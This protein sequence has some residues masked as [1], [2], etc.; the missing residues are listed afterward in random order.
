MVCVSALVSEASINIDTMA[1]SLSNTIR[2]LERQKDDNAINFIDMRGKLTSCGENTEEDRNREV[3]QLTEAIQSYSSRLKVFSLHNNLLSNG[4][5][6]ALIKVLGDLVVLEKLVIFHHDLKD[7]M[8]GLLVDRLSGSYINSDIRNWDDPKIYENNAAERPSVSGLKE[9]YL[10][11]CNIGCKGALKI[12]EALVDSSLPSENVNRLKCLQV[13]SLG[14][15]KIDKE[16]GLSL[17]KVFASYPSLHRMVLHGNEGLTSDTDEEFLRY[18]FD[19]NGWQQSIGSQ[20]IHAAP[21][22]MIASLVIPYV[23]SRWTRDRVLIRPYELSRERLLEAICKKDS[24]FVD[25]KFEEMPEMISWVGR[26]GMCS[27]PPSCQ[28]QLSED[29]RGL[30][31]SDGCHECA[32]CNNIHL[33]DIYLIMKRLP[34]LAEWFQGA[35]L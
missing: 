20:R 11:H 29:S 6:P 31:H 1:A 30:C 23:R 8:V 24:T 19:P 27:K 25:D 9:L 16:G 2:R 17:A 10:S 34:H 33:N 21:M 35:K 28:S 14:S 15:N 26:V 18:A 7:D 5:M 32:A 3:L 13:L 12:A 22:N 4:E